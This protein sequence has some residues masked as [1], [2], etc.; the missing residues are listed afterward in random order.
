LDG[1]ELPVVFPVLK[2]QKSQREKK[3]SGESS[4][5]MMLAGFQSKTSNS[6]GDL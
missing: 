2:K 3:Q 1:E 6:I 4:H 5:V